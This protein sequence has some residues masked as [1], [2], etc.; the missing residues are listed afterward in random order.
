MTGMDSNAD[1]LGL[2]IFEFRSNLEIFADV[3]SSALDVFRG[4]QKPLPLMR[5]LKTCQ[6]SDFLSRFDTLDSFEKEM[7]ECS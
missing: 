1:H 6:S 4:C 7:G 3:M 2:V 5:C